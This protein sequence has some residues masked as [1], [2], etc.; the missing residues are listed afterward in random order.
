MSIRRGEKESIDSTGY[1]DKLVVGVG[2]N[3]KEGADEF[4]ERYSKIGHSL[5]T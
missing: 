3:H 5:Y 2:K 1:Q 4:W